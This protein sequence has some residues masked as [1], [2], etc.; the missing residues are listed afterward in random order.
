MLSLRQCLR[1]WKIL[2][3]YI[4]SIWKNLKHYFCVTRFHLFHAIHAL[5]HGT[6]KISLKL[7]IS[8]FWK[9]MTKNIKTYAFANKSFNVLK[10]NTVLAFFK[11]LALGQR[12]R[13]VDFL[14]FLECDVP[15][16]FYCYTF[17]NNRD[18]SNLLLSSL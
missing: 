16:S 14:Q 9:L 3:H 12:L 18:I 8:G 10:T 15:S 5:Q 1:F 2:S 6:G 17:G 7:Y 13:N 11:L 4:I